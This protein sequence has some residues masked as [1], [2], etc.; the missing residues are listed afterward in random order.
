MPKAVLTAAAKVLFRETN[1]FTSAARRFSLRRAAWKEVANFFGSIFRFPANK[2][3]AVESS[4]HAPSRV[5]G[6]L[7]RG[8]AQFFCRPDVDRMEE[9]LQEADPVQMCVLAA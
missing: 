1:S 5:S 4:S 8:A 7:S 9:D 3:S 2:T 6:R